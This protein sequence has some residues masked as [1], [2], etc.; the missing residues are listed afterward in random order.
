MDSLM[1]GEESYLIVENFCYMSV[2]NH[3]FQKLITCLG[4][5]DKAETIGFSFYLDL[6]M[7]LDWL[8]FRKDLKNS[9]GIN[10]QSSLLRVCIYSSFLPSTCPFAS[11]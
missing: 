5:Y 10:C 3:V 1:K 7:H 2:G 6:S 9:L 11:I 4:M 8:F